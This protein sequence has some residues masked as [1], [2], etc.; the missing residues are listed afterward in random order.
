LTLEL[1]AT[2][3]RKSTPEQFSDKVATN[4]LLGIKPVSQLGVIVFYG[5]E[6]TFVNYHTTARLYCFPTIV[7]YMQF[8]SA[9]LQ[10]SMS[11]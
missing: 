11:F 7:P 5:K 3:R 6:V 10:L 9:P 4:K 2:T 8:S 1:I